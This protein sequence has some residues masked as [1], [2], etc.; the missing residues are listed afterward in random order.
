MIFKSIKI[1][2]IK[3]NYIEKAYLM[4]SIII[5]SS[6]ISTKKTLKSIISIVCWK[7]IKINIRWMNEWMEKMKAIALWNTTKFGESQFCDGHFE[8]SRI[9]LCLNDTCLFH[10]HQINKTKRENQQ[11][12]VLLS[13]VT[14]HNWGEN[15]SKSVR[16]VIFGTF[17]RIHPQP[18]TSLHFSSSTN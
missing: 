7:S 16:N 13:C 5:I 6:T 12:D 9:R 3:S 18:I 14:I 17:P 10:C 1:G 8:F 11:N 4:S 2:Y 15:R